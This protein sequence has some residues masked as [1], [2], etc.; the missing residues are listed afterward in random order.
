M[1]YNIFTIQVLDRTSYRQRVYL[2]ELWNNATRW[3]RFAARPRDWRRRCDG[4]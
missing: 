1:K 3:W 4:F 2:G